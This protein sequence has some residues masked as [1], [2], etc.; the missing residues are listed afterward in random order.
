[1][2]G[3]TVSNWSATAR[4]TLSGSFVVRSLM[5]NLS[6]HV[7]VYV[8]SFPFVPSTWLKSKAFWSKAFLSLLMWSLTCPDGRQISHK[9]GRRVCHYHRR[10]LHCAH[11]LAVLCLFSVKSS[12]ST[13]HPRGTYMKHEK[14]LQCYKARPNSSLACTT[15]VANGA[16]FV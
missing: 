5:G 10:N 1:M 12:V 14:W 16:W 8:P 15:G 3:D 7:P 11:K 2:G 13:R 9:N 6:I 4:E